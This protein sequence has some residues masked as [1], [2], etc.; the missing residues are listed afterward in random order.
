MHVGTAE[1]ALALLAAQPFDAILMDVNLPGM[2]GWE[3]TK[4]IRADQ[5]PQIATLPVIGISAQVLTQDI[6]AQLAAGM[7]DFVAKPVAPERLAQA[8][9]R[10]TGCTT[11]RNAAKPVPR[12]AA[13]DDLV[14]DLG[15]AKARD[16]AHLFLATLTEQANSLTTAAERRDAKAVYTAAHSL[17]GA[18]GNFA[19]AD[20]VGELQRVEDLAALG[21]IEP[22]QT[23]LALVTQA[24]AVILAGVNDLVSLTAP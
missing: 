3:A 15:A 10:S 19:L 24:R 16:L 4:I 23:L 18:A 1:A 22:L 2:T 6:A 7:D 11:G 17:K 8:L 13:L 20:L 12:P 9:A 14:R 21:K 5:N